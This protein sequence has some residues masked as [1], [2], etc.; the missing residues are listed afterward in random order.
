MIWQ[1]N[2]DFGGSGLTMKLH[3]VFHCSFLAPASSGVKHSRFQWNWLT[4]SL[5]AAIGRTLKFPMVSMAKALRHCWRAILADLSRTPTAEAHF[6][7][8]LIALAQGSTWEDLEKMRNADRERAGTHKCLS[9]GSVQYRLAGGSII[10]ADA[11]LYGR[12]RTCL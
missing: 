9:E 3:P 12:C 6:E 1:V 2:T 8:L 10:D 7:E 4:C 11:H 5:R